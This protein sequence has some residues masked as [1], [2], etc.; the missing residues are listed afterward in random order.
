MPKIVV[1]GEALIDVFADNGVPLRQAEDLHPSPGGAPANVAVALARLGADVGFI[2]K[3]GED[4][5]G[6]LLSDLLTDEGVDTSYFV[7]DVRAP[8]MLAIVATP[9]PTEQHFVLYNGASALL[10]PNDLSYE[11]VSSAE[12]FV[13]G[14][15]T[16]ASASRDAAVQA[17]RWAR[18]ANRHV[19]FDVN[20]RPA[21]WPDLDNARYC[22]E[23]SVALANVVKLNETELEFLT[24]VGDPALGSERLLK[25]DVELC[26][27][28]MGGEGA[29]F[30][31][32]IAKGRVPARSV[33]VRDTT[34]SGDAFVAGLAFQLSV[35]GQPIRDLEENALR[36]MIAF[37]NACGGLAATQIGAMSASPTLD[38]V[39]E[40]LGE[41]SV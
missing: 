3:V 36:Q 22:I 17:A 34:G 6:Y 25:H 21:L 37:A 31:N 23:E 16:L 5:F 27:V 11:Y 2:G 18:A 29:Y 7:T 9:S 32:G 12:I 15:V 10:S 14:S 41:D 4:E 20:L 28:S 40:L 33:N 24:G 26:C 1:L 39:K 38:A 35:L 13:Y 19:V 8:T 30:N